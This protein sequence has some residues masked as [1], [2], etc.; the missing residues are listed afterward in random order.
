MAQDAHNKA[1]EHHENAAKAHRMAAEHH[2]KGD[3]ASAKKH[4][5]TALDYSGKAHEASK[6]AHEK[7]FTTEAACGSNNPTGG[8]T[9]FGHQVVLLAVTDTPPP[10]SKQG[11]HFLSSPSFFFP[12]LSRNPTGTLAGFRSNALFT[13]QLLPYGRQELHLRVETSWPAACAALSRR[14]VQFPSLGCQSRVQTRI[15]TAANKCRCVHVFGFLG[16]E[17]DPA[18]MDLETWAS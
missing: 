6:A 11:E 13:R 7:S 15:A 10:P 4:S 16:E 1:A 3:H 2:G 12:L 14:V 5:A 17:H 18:R 9:G 8:H